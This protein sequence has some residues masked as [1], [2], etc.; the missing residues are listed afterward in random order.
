MSGAVLCCR[1]AFISRTR[2][3]STFRKEGRDPA[4]AFLTPWE[5][6]ITDQHFERYDRRAQVAC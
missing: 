1:T 6:D 4:E 5:A 2:A 3:G